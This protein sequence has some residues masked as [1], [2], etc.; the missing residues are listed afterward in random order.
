MS[1]FIKTISKILGVVIII[2][3]ILA[4]LLWITTLQPADVETQAITCPENAPTLQSGQ[5][6]KLMTYNIQYMAGKNYHF[7]YEGGED[8]RPGTEDSH[9]FKIQT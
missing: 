5:S 6:L 7:W 1:K 2:V 9:Y 8:E 3:A 4:G